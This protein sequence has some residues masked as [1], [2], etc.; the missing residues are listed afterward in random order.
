[1]ETDEDSQKL[2]LF[3]SKASDETLKDLQKD[4]QARRKK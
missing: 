1:M 2:N 3:S 4:I